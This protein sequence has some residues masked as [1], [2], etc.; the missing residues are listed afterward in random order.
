MLVC[1]TKNKN[2]EGVTHTLI[3]SDFRENLD[4]VKDFDSCWCTF[5][6]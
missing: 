5:L 1:V 2:D 6:L 4:S 3:F